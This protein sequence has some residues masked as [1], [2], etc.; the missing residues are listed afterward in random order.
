MPAKGKIAAY[1]R[2]KYGPRKD[3]RPQARAKLFS[4]MRELVHSNAVIRSDSNPSYVGDVRKYFPK[5]SHITVLGGRGAVVGQGELKK[6]RWDP[7][8]SLNHTCAMMRANINRLIRKTWCTTKKPSELAGH[9]AIYALEHNRRL[10][11]TQ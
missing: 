7:I 5:S 10:A 4:E 9:I 3:F 6:L 2:K 1:S 11:A 8:F